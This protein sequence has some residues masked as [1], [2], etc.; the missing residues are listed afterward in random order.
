MKKLLF[1]L[2]FVACLSACAMSSTVPFQV[3][4]TPPGAQIY[5]NHVLMGVAPIQIE[6]ACDKHWACPAGD[7]CRW[8][9][10]EGMDE[11][12][13][14]PTNDNQGPSQ[15]KRVDACQGKAGSGYID[16]DFGL[17]GGQGG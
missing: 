14:Y 13:A 11:I 4:S 15:S 7:S 3:S 8:E 10:H 1:G 2:F 6:L 12:T 5:V 16:F 9:F 17:N